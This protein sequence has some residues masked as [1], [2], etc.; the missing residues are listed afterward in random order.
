MNCPS[1]KKPIDCKHSPALQALLQQALDVKANVEKKAAERA[2]FEEL[3][4][5]PRLK[6]P[7]DHYFNKLGEFAMFKLAYYPCHKC[8]S[9]YFGGMIDCG[10]NQN[11]L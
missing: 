3:D 6:D 2:K 11:A 5:N 10:D 7:N 9:P 8:K 4:K 1:C